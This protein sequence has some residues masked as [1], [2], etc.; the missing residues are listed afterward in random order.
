M[1][2]FILAMSLSTIQII[3]NKYDVL[4]HNCKAFLHMFR[5]TNEKKKLNK[6]GY[7]DL[8]KKK[9]CEVETFL[10]VFCAFV[11]QMSTSV[12]QIHTIAKIEQSQMKNNVSVY[13]CLLCCFI[14][15][16]YYF[17]LRMLKCHCECFIILLLTYLLPVVSE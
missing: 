1:I 10:T 8:M 14:V 16:L 4:V 17:I 6:I 13:D 2:E 15:I 7:F 9:I 5:K 11:S 12:L 3:P